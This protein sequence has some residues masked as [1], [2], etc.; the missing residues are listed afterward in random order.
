MRIKVLF[1]KKLQF[2]ARMIIIM[3]EVENF[4]RPRLSASRNLENFI[5]NISH[6]SSAALVLFI[7]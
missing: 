4:P 5:K 7:M 1:G 3:I 6:F 2:Y